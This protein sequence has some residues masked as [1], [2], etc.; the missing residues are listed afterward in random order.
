MGGFDRH[1]K[2]GHGFSAYD[3]RVRVTEVREIVSNNIVL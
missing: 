1:R 3:R 2:R